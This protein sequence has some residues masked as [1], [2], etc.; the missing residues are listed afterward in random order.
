MVTINTV[1]CYDTDELLKYSKFL[2]LVSS[3]DMS[4][5]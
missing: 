5:N 3:V 1:P 4:S 2:E